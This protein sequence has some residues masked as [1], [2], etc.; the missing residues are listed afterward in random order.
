MVR[1]PQFLKP[2]P[3]MCTAYSIACRSWLVHT[4]STCRFNDVRELKKAPVNYGFAE[5]SKRRRP[6]LS[7]DRNNNST[8]GRGPGTSFWVTGQVSVERNV[9]L[10][11]FE[12]GET[13]DRL[14]SARS[15]ARW[16]T[17]VTTEVQCGELGPVFTD[18][19]VLAHPASDESV[20]EMQPGF[21]RMATDSEDTGLTPSPPHSFIAR[22]Y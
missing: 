21:N 14:L 18:G 17:E 5:I 8:W 6:K 3:N 7:A 10:D 22:Q 13:M 2:C 4:S 20:P 9:L 19:T 12:P 15:G 1:V 11:V 16:L